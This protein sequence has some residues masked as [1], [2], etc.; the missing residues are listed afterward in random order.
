METSSF[1]QYSLVL[2][3]AA[4]IAVPLAKRAR[5]G[6][7]LGYLAA[8]ALIGPSLLNLVGNADEIAKISELGVI[9]MLFVIGLELSPQRLWLMRRQVFGWGTAQVISSALAISAISLAL[10]LSWKVALVI[11]LGLA[12][13]S[14]AIGL[15][16]LAERKELQSAHGRLGFAILLLQDVAAIPILALVPLLAK[17]HHSAGAIPDIYAV[18]RVV[19]AIALVIL[20][21]RVLLRPLFR[22][23]ARTQI[24]E[25]FTASALLVVLGT[26]WLLQ[27]AGISMSL[28]AFLAGVLLAD[29]EYRHEIEARVD[30]FKGL[31]LGLFFISVGMSANVR[32]LAEQPLLILGLLL[33]L[34]VLKGAILFMLGRLASEGSGTALKLGAVLS[35]GGEFAFVIFTLA[36]QN[37]LMDAHLHDLLI[38]VVT[39]SMALTPVLVLACTQWLPKA[40]STKPAYDHIDEAEPPQVII[41]GF[42]RFGQIVA[43]VLRANKIR[44]TAIENS[45]EQVE[46]SRRFGNRIYYGDPT[47]SDLL[48]AAHIDKVELFIVATDDPE[49]NIRTARLVRRMYPQ[50]KVFARAR[51]RQH[52]FRLMDLGALIERETFHSSLVL[53]RRVLEAL[54][55]SPELAAQRVTAFREFDEKLL[56]EQH[57]IY[58]DETAIMQNSRE[59][60]RDLD[61][62]FEADIAGEKESQ[63]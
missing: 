17:S 32:L 37:R 59:A 12:L 50:L 5:L 6:A 9:L 56:A 22:V 14:T 34:V 19:A 45:I 8:G 2:L 63:T 11:G 33:G 7:V 31:L 23:A 43:R 42:G 61:N 28:G 55:M 41:A 1:L 13:S 24:S 53:S 16:T 47:R 35:Q 20:G 51:N 3:L 44:F 62:L 54:G 15:Q 29:S 60:Q 26:A 36:K 25:V 52:A 58:D 10:G 18:L 4:V 40:E 46:I 39:L 49:A 30:P 48:R 38:V 27:Q 21:G 57:L